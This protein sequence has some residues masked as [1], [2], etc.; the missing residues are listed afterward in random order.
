MIVTDNS[1]RTPKQDIIK[2][3]Q[4]TRAQCLNCREFGGVKTPNC[5]KHYP[6]PATNTL[7]NSILRQKVSYTGPT[8]E[9]IGLHT[10]YITTAVKLRQPKIQLPANYFQFKH[11]TCLLKSGAEMFR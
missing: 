3:S 4:I 9:P 2:L 8:V 6:P 11:S 10:I 5:F 1:M 7:S